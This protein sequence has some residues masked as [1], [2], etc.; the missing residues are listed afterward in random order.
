MNHFKK[1]YV[2]TAKGSAD[3]RASIIA[4]VIQKLCVLLP[5]VVTMAMASMVLK[6]MQAEKLDIQRLLLITAVGVVAAVV[7]IVATR[8]QYRKTNIPTYH[9]SERLRL[10]MADKISRLSMFYINRTNLSELAGT[11]MDDCAQ[12]ESILSGVVPELYS[13]IITVPLS[14]A[15]LAIFDWRLSLE[16]FVF[17][18][19]SVLIQLA[20][21]KTQERLTEKQLVSKHEASDKLHEY[22][23]G[24]QEIRANGLAINEKTQLYKAL[25]GLRLSSLKVETMSGVFTAGA[26]AFLQLGVGLVVYLAGTFISNGQM[27]LITAILFF[28]SIYIVY[29]PASAALSLM[30]TLM[31]MQKSTERI[32]TLLAQPEHGGEL[33]TELTGFDI[34]FEDV[35]FG[36]DERPVLEHLSFTAQ[37]GCITALV[38]A[39]GSGKSTIASLAAGFYTPGSGRITVGGQDISAL[40]QECYWKYVSCVFQEVVLFNDTVYNNILIGNPDATREMVLE[41]ARNA[42]CDEFIERLPEGIDTVLAEN[43]KSLSGGERQRISI[44]R[45]LLKNAP[46]II[47]DEATS[48]LDAENE[49]YI[50]KAISCLIK[51]KTAI[52]I[53]HR[54]RNIENA[55]RIVVIEN[56]AAE[57]TGTHEELIEKQGVY[58][59]LVDYQTSGG[60]W[61]CRN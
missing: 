24:M 3:L 1:H 21:M 12:S 45:A 18:P 17:V 2:I 16:A 51:D 19:L 57:E 7:M 61:R 25:D 5:L 38:G 27:S 35:C 58:K 10:S 41:A 20:T 6:G 22:I 56:K 43:G 50:Q 40:K 26:D 13:S 11:L 53:A 54:L 29:R 15:L 33:E 39:S 32:R 23:G 49:Y 44:A 59:K 52:I 30:P 36:Y 9:E 55:D 60:Q 42:C 47:L 46:V 4:T 31:Y 8:I 37:Q 14:F 34:C 28:A 48:C